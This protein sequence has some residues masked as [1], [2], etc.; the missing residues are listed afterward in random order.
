LKPDKGCWVVDSG[1]RWIFDDDRLIGYEGLEGSIIDI[2]AADAKVADPSEYIEITI[3]RQPQY[4][5]TQN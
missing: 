2:V 5:H 3:D 1:R 4:D